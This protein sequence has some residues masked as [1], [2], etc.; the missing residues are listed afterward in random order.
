MK[1]NISS[2]LLKKSM[3]A[4]QSLLTEHQVFLTADADN[5]LLIVEAG[6]GGLYLKQKLQ[7]QVS[8]GGSTVLNSSY[9]SSL[10]LTDSVELKTFGS[11]LAFISGKLSGK[12]ETHQSY[13]KIVDQ[14][15]SEEITV[16][17][18]ISKD[19][20]SKAV[21]K[22][23]FSAIMAASQEGLRVKVDEYLTL[24][25]TDQWRLSL[26]KDKLPEKKNT[27]DF[28]IKPEVLSAAIN[29]I[30]DQ[31]VWL[32]LSNG[33]IKIASPSF[34]FYHPT[35]Q[36]EPTD[37]EGWLGDLD[38]KDKICE[39]SAQTA[40][41]LGLITGVG[42]ITHGSSNEVKLACKLHGK[43]LKVEVGAAHGSA[44]GEMALE[45]SDADNHQVTLSFKYTVEMLSLLKDGD[46]KIA[47]YEP[48]IILTSGDGR[49]TSVVPTTTV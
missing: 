11:S 40:D 27:I 32:G 19:I 1:L 4:V 9:I 36:T 45:E 29:K 28:M 21:A 47:F 35:I 46:V 43:T 5:N 22:T 42:S 38:P 23:N 2:D 26:Y 44:K 7:A 6:N 12:L 24:S 25:T 30:E 20:F 16:Q 41:I 48:Y 8:E 31:E 17:I 3:S 37:I 49:C 10:R 34:E 18:Q 33:I 13:Q 14:R 39:I 15:P